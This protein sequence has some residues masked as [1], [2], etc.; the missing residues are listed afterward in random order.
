MQKTTTAILERNGGMHR[1]KQ[2]RQV[3]AMLQGHGYTRPRLYHL[4]LLDELDGRD[5]TRFLKALKAICLKL[6]QDG[7]ATRWR[8]C[9]ERDDEK[10]LHFHVFLLVDAT[11]KN[12]CAIINTKPDGW[13]RTMLARRAMR[14]HLSQ[15]K[16]DMHRVGGTVQGRRKSYA[17]LAGDKLA[18]CMEWLSY[19]VKA[20]SKPD[21]IRNLY[22]SSRDSRHTPR[23]ADAEAR[24]ASSMALAPTP[25]SVVLDAMPLACGARDSRA[26]AQ[27]IPD[28]ADARQGP[29]AGSSPARIALAAARAARSAK[30]NISP[31]RQELATAHL[32]RPAAAQLH[33]E[34]R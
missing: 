9:L 31:A 6:R 5:A 22:F 14:V 27:P 17:S 18:D 24:T 13:L 26:A 23:V 30:A 8:A 7:I 20:R 21:D 29:Y 3:K 4:V 28:A 11:V 10:G 2:Y 34:P 1:P 16:A 15:P 33:G 12:P 32:A 25:P 19:L